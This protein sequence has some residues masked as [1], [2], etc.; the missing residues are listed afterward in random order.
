MQKT[1][2]VFGSAIPIEGSE[3]YELAYLLGKKL[4]EKNYSVCT[5]G[6]S[7]IMEAVS[8]GAFDSGG[9]IYGV[10][11]ENWKSTPNPFITIEIRAKNLFERIS[12]LIEMSDGFIVLQGGTG[13][14]LELAA[15]WEF[16]NKGLIEIKPIV[17]HSDLWKQI[18]LLMN[19]QLK[20]ENKRIDLIDTAETVD[21]ILTK[22]E[23][24]F[25]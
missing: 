19:N 16:M 15:I 11:L 14:L 24:K 2:T 20:L 12:K 21:E 23:A 10:T 4:S 1:I 3:Q 17:C 18:V 22:L 13:T 6:Y 25:G 9:N 5:G 7:G 8:K